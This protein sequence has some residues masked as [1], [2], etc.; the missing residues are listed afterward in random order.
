MGGCIS[1]RCVHCTRHAI[2]FSSEVLG[3]FLLRCVRVREKHVSGLGAL[4]VLSSV[5]LYAF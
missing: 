4:R 3:V 2:N 5:C 1:Q